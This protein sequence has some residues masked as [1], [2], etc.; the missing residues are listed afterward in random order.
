MTVCSYL[1]EAIWRSQLKSQTVYTYLFLEG[2]KSFLV[3]WHLKLACV[4]QRSTYFPFSDSCK[5]FSM[6]PNSQLKK[7]EQWKSLQHLGMEW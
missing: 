4:K 3:L 7:N 2:I 5:I 1:Q 6:S